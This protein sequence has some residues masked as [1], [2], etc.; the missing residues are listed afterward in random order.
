MMAIH[1]GTRACVNCGTVRYTI[2]GRGYCSRCYYIVRR[3]EE[4]RAWDVSKLEK[5]PHFPKSGYDLVCPSGK[6][7]RNYYFP[8]YWEKMFPQIK[9][10]TIEELEK[11]LLHLMLAESELAG[12]IDG[13]AIELKLAWLAHKARARDKRVLRGIASAINGHFT[14]QQR[15]LLFKWLNEICESIKWEGI[16]PWIGSTDGY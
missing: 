10:H 14:P 7:V 15:K 6:K 13:Y 3:I 12:P 5:L 1:R 16:A 4:A 9:Q 11:R 8:E 2:K